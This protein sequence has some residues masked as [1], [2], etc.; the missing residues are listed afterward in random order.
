MGGLGNQLFQLAAGLSYCD[1][2]TTLVDNLGNP[3]RSKLDQP[4]IASFTLPESVN[5]LQHEARRD[6]KGGG[7]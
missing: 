2:S 1:E 4:E 6:T 5:V 3:R 7:P